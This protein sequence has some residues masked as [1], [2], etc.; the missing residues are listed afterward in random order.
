MPHISTKRHL[1]VQPGHLVVDTNGLRATVLIV[2]ITVSAVA[3]GIVAAYLVIVQVEI[4]IVIAE[5]R[6]ID[7]SRGR[8][9]A[10]RFDQVLDERGQRGKRVGTSQQGQ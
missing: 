4:Q 5:K 8:R 10:E 2:V 3:A 6:H 1:V 7:F 9:L